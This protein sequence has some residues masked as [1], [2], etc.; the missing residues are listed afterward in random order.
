M[1]DIMQENYKKLFFK[2]CNSLTEKNKLFQY[3]Y[4]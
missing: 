2:K 1:K 4:L 3:I